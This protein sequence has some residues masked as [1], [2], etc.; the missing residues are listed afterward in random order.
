MVLAHARPLN[1]RQWAAHFGV[2][3]RTIRTW[4]AEGMVLDIWAAPAAS[5]WRALLAEAI[6]FLWANI[7]FLEGCQ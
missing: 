2:S 1:A 5:Q 4:M 3:L 6:G 7:S